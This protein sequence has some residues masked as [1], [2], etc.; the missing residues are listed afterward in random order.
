MKK[1]NAQNMT[2]IETE[3]LAKLRERV[4]KL[5]YDAIT[6]SLNLAIAYESIDQRDAEIARLKED[7]KRL[8]WF[9]QHHGF[10]YEVEEEWY[11]DWWSQPAIEGAD[12]DTDEPQNTWREAIDAAI[13]AAGEKGRV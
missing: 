4:N 7:E 11:C 10:V 9:V 3:E 12:C 2:W 5:E 8:E 13:A 1:L 6:A